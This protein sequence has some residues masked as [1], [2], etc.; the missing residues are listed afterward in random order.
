[1][2]RLVIICSML[3]LL[4]GC[5]NPGVQNKYTKEHVIV[6]TDSEFK[7]QVITIN[8]GDTVTWLNQ[9]ANSRTSTS[10]RSWIDETYTEYNLVGELWDSGDISPGNSFSLVFTDSGEYDYISLPLFHWES[11]V[12]GLKG[13]VKVE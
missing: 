8:K 13:T 4:T 6:I 9:G 11:F 12:I 3:A 2:I 10:W 5:Y 1:M 7:P